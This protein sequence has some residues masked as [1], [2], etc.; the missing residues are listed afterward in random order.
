MS[1]SRTLQYLESFV[2]YEKK[3]DFTYPQSFKLDRMRAVL[4]ALGNPERAVPCIHVAG[5]KGKGSTCAVSA[6]I[7]R[8]AGYAVGLYT[9]PHLS[10]L[11][12][13]IRVLSGVSQESVPAADFEGMIAPRELE[14]LVERV[15]PALEAFRGSREADAITFFEV[16]TALAFVH[17]RDKRLDCAV[18]ETGIGGRLDATNV[19]EA[20]VSVI[21]P[22]SFE[23]TA[24]LGS[25]I[26]LIAAEK[27]GIIKAQRRQKEG[28]SA[29]VA[30]TA[31]QRPEALEVIRA[32]CE[33][34]GVALYEAGVHF[35]C[36]KED[37]GLTIR[38]LSGVYRSLRPALLGDHQ[39]SNAA[40]ATVA[41]EAFARSRGAGLRAADVERGVSRAV[42][43]GRCEIVPGEPSIMLDVAH[44]VDSV[45]ALCR[46]IEQVARPGRIVLVFGVSRDKDIEGMC[47]LLERIAD[48]VV[49]TRSRNPRA[50][51]PSDMRAHFR[52]LRAVCI[53][54][55]PEALRQARRLAG[56]HDT[57]VVCGSVFVVGE[58]RNEIFRDR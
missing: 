33:K 38:G 54:Q 15:R 32:R 24:L 45:Q 46:T 50:R 41:A 6:S 27:A 13:R 51:S 53:E 23:H 22:I 18:I 10:D 56:P 17:F 14:S 36:Q 4:A 2:N 20:A 8:E 49:L 39:L 9:S 31:P 16:Y 35:S 30:V 11:R 52:S 40:V 57:I 37:G 12:E 7:L 28:W 34:E 47:A 19:V 26:P 5:T 48:A 1:F 55:I 25:T 43:P 21:T 29:P 44:N 42:W 58:A 3:N